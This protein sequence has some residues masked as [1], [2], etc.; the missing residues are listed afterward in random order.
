VRLSPPATDAAKFRLLRFYAL[1][2][3]PVLVAVLIALFILQRQEEKFFAQVQDEQ[4]QFFKS[5]Q[6][7]LARQN[8]A[9]AR[10]SLLA[11]HEAGHLNLTRIVANTM[12]ETDFAPLVRAAQALPVEPCRRS[13]AKAGDGTDAARR[14]CVA[15]LGKRIRALPGF[16]ALDRKAYAAMHASTVFKIK[17]FDLRGV[18][19]YSSEHAQ[20]GEDA[21]GNAGWRSAAAGRPAGE[22]THRDRFSAFEGVVENRDLISTYVPVRSGP[23]NEVV[24]VFEL[25]SDVTPFLGLIQANSKAIAGS[26]AATDLAAS[27]ASQQNLEKVIDSSNRFLLLVG[28]LL[29]LLYG[30][31]LL[32]VRA[33]QRIIDRQRLAQEEAAAREQLWHREKMAALST[34]AANVS[35]EVG[36]PLTVIACIAQM[37]PDDRGAAG[38]PGGGLPAK[39]LE[40]TNRIAKMMRRISDFAT[41]RSESTEWIEINPML[42]AVCEFQSFDLRY[43][44]TAIEF[45]PGEGLPACELVPDCL[46]EVMMNLLQACAA[47]RAAGEPERTIRVSTRARDGQVCIEVGRHASATGERLSIDAVSTDRRFETVRRRVDDMGARLEIESTQIRIVLPSKPDAPA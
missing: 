1:A 20:I 7:E 19:V 46:N 29:L 9:A 38:D 41:A 34:M 23:D 39:I 26:I 43:G 11:V 47:L 10:S 4:A 37:L 40:Q 31:S 3:L 8:D 28:G 27:K 13:G 30:T 36:N 2:T 44:R 14:A 22:L 42:A 24:G 16:V 12:W 32:I 33:G 21:A 45:S 6:A 18:T 17:V 25:Y 15:D 5:A 35:H